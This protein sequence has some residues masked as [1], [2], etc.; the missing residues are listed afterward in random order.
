VSLL[1]IQ[2][3]AQVILHHT[4]HQGVADLSVASEMDNMPRDAPFLI[5]SM[6]TYATSVPLT[7]QKEIVIIKQFSVPF[8][9]LKSL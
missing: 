7:R 6:S 9:Q 4:K 2:P 1:L 5:A 8:L 3:L